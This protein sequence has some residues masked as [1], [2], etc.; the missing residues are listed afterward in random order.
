MAI[1][2]L[3]VRNL[4]GERANEGGPVEVVRDFTYQFRPGAFYELSGSEVHGKSLMLHLLGLLSPPKSGDIFVDG[5]LVNHLDVDGLSY[6]RNRKYGFLFSAP[7]LLP[8]FTVLEN[9]AIP[10]FKIAEVDALEAKVIVEEILEML[11]ISRIAS[12]AVEDLKGLDGMLAALAR[13]LVHHPR[14]LIAESVGCN[15]QEYEANALLSILRESGRRLGLTVIATLASHVSWGLAD[16]CLEFG[17]RE[18]KEFIRRN[19]SG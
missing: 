6:V 9:V 1:D 11:G 10:L 14:V 19:P 16:V 17:P 5:S 8:T 18:V 2:P 15:L 4:S 3:M 7:F 13:A 12:A